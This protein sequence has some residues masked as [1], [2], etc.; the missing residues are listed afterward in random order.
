MEDLIS[1]ECYLVDL[2]RSIGFWT[3][4]GEKKSG[5]RVRENEMDKVFKQFLEMYFHSILCSHCYMES[6]SI[7]L[8]PW[9]FRIEELGF[10]SG[11]YFF[12]IITFNN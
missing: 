6:F 4:K 1:L 3:K 8:D 2:V 11:V 9:L 7:F 5:G 12:K 10:P